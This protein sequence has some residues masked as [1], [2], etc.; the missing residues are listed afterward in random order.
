MDSMLSPES[1]MSVL[2][3]Y[4]IAVGGESV[5]ARIDAVES[6]DAEQGVATIRFLRLLRDE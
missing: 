1:R 5:I 6:Y 4:R 3:L 2:S